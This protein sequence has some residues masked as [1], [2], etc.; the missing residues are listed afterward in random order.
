MTRARGR[1]EAGGDSVSRHAA[2]EVEEAE[3]EEAAG[4]AGV[5]GGRRADVQVATQ[6]TVPPTTKDTSAKCVTLQYE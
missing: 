5:G 4:G 3:V 2:A 1:G 6:P